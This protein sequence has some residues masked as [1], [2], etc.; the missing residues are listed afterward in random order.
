MNYDGYAAIYD[1][2]GQIRFALLTAMYLEDV[3][4]AH[5][6]DGRRMLDVACGTGTLALMM[7]ERGWQVTGLDAAPAMLAQAV[8]KAVAGG[9]TA[10]WMV[11]DMADLT[12]L[13]PAAAF[14]LV[15]CTYDS[16]N[17]LTGEAALQRFL[18]G[19]AQVLRPGGVGYFDINTEYFLAN[20]WGDCSVSRRHG[21]FQIEQ[22]AY[23]AVSRSSTLLLT[24]FV[25][26]DLQGYERVDEVHIERAYPRAEIAAA[27]QTAGL[28]VEAVYD[29]FTRQPAHAASQRECWVVRRP[30]EGVR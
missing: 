13:L 11:G 28:L 14:D 1:G 27:L 26:D 3:L 8:E 16:I 7:E 19:L 24:A 15:T 12:E 10:R 29:G 18:S 25:G 6:I 5:P 2:S 30:A 20:E 9:S 4:S 21:L 22:S 23:D 17:Y